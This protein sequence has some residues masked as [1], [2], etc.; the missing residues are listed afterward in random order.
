VQNIGVR[1]LLDEG[2]I[3]IID[4]LLHK[5]QEQR[6][7]SLCTEGPLCQTVAKHAFFLADT[8]PHIVVFLAS[9]PK[10]HSGRA[11]LPTHQE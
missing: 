8:A 4:D 7:L 2:V 6:V 11:T 5:I 3:E 1:E 10:R 9:S